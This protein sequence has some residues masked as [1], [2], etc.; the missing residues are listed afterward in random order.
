MV[1]TK[2]DVKTTFTTSILGKI[3]VECAYDI[4]FG[5]NLMTLSTSVL[6]QPMFYII[7]LKILYVLQ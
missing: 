4:N 1:I 3:D 2:T 7:F 6:N 5:R